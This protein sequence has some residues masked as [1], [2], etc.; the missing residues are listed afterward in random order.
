MKTWYS[1]K[2]LREILHISPQY[3]YALK[4]SG[5]VKT[6]EIALGKYL[7]TLPEGF[8]NE[9]EVEPEK[10]LE[11]LELLQTAIKNNK[12]INLKIEIL[13]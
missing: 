11:I 2:E 4:K 5:R 6:K 10:Q 13:S 8:E 9:I 1:S 12:K 7:Y 3:L